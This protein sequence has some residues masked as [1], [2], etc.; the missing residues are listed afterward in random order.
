MKSKLLP[1]NSP[2]IF[3]LFA[4]TA[5]TVFTV[6]AIPAIAAAGTVT[7]SGSTSVYPLSLKLA[8]AYNKETKGKAKFKIAQGGSDVG[9]ADA[10]AGRVT[11]GMS[12][13]DP[14]TSD[15]GGIVFNKIARDAVC[16]ISNKSNAL[17]AL[18]QA[19]IA[20]IFSGSTKKWSD[21]SGA[22]VSGTINLYVRTAASGTQDAFQELFMGERRISSAAATK[23]SNGLIQQ[24]V[25]SDANG[26]G[27]VSADFVSGVSAIPYGG[28]PCNLKNAKSGRYPGTRNFWM[29]T[30]G[31]AKG[32]A[33]KFIK[34]IQKSKAAK[35]IVASNWVPI[36]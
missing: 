18:S 16:V 25:K 14:Q 6:L 33:K 15:P 29:V 24:A 8:K 22:Q 23:S 27:Y 7:M 26:I 13:R 32:D 9:V 35:R 5:L 10:A 36:K 20:A 21:I 4:V 17:P 3:K 31:K 12:S 1:K 2:K 28:V 19:Q 34:W 30:R 11:I